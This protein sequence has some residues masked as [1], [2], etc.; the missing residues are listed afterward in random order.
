MFGSNFPGNWMQNNEI[1]LFILL[2]GGNE[3]G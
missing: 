1:T 3:N 2:K